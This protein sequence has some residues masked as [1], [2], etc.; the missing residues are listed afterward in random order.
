MVSIYLICRAI[1]SCAGEYFL[2]VSVCACVWPSSSI[3][4][5][6]QFNTFRLGV[7]PVYDMR[8][9]H[10]NQPGPHPSVC[11]Y[12]NNTRYTKYIRSIYIYFSKR[13]QNRLFCCSL[14][15]HVLGT[16]HPLRARDLT[17]KKCD[18]R[19]VSHHSYI[20]IDKTAV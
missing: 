2:W 8:G 18:V 10:Q 16:S 19:D 6:H 13:Q 17:R 7:V 11:L 20:M 5:G 15:V 3:H 1:V 4:S 14:C 9:A 12:S